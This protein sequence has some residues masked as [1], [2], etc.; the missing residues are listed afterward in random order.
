LGADDWG[1]AGLFETMATLTCAGIR[2]AGAGKNIDEARQPTYVDLHGACRLIVFGLG[3]LT[4]GVAPSWAA[5][6]GKAGIEVQGDPSD[7]TAAEMA[8]R[9]PRVRRPGHVVIA[10]IHRGSNW[11]HDVPESFVRVA[12][13]LIDAGISVVH[14][15]SSNHIRPVEV[16]GNRL[17]LYGCGDFINPSLARVVNDGARRGWARRAR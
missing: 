3:S 7:A 10:S 15:H 13:S 1:R 4:S 16:Y 9:V 14:G 17:I 8:E 2:V 11:G 6:E 12:R 5:S